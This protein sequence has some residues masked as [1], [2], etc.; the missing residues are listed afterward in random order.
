MKKLNQIQSTGFICIGI[1]VLLEVFG[2]MTGVQALSIAAA[3][4]LL[5]CIA[6]YLMFFRCPHC[7]AFLGGRY[8]SAIKE[9]NGEQVCPHC[10]CRLE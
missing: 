4:L 5:G 8:G 7:G 10:G 2:A 6:G 3:V 1:A 9:V